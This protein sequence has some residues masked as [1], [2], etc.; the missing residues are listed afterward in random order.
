MTANTNPK[1][2]VRFGYIHADALHPE[3]V[4]ALLYGSQAKNLSY[5]Q[6]REEHMARARSEF[7]SE[8]TFTDEFDA[9]FEEDKFSER[10][11]GEEECIEGTYKGVS[12][13]T[14]WLGGALNFFICASPVTVLVNSL[15]SPCVPNAGNLDSGF[16][17]FKDEGDSGFLCYGV[18][19]DWLD[20]ERL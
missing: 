9:N 6:A 18:P 12:Y 20:E 19:A 10:Y 2:G 15:C 8:R 11:Q 1:T 14:S 16:A 13:C 17:V 5:E 4:D 3:V 7:E